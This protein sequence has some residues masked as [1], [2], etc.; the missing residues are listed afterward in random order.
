MPEKSD[1]RSTNSSMRVALLAVSLVSWFGA[2]T[3]LGVLMYRTEGVSA[4]LLVPVIL[5]S[6]V[7]SAIL[8][9]FKW[10]AFRGGQAIAEWFL[11]ILGIGSLAAAGWFAPKL[12][13]L[14]L[15]D[16]DSSRINEEW[17]AKVVAACRQRSGV[18]PSSQQD[19]LAVIYLSPGKEVASFIPDGFKPQV[20]VEFPD[21]TIWTN[22]DAVRTAYVFG[23]FQRT[24]GLKAVD[25][26]TLNVRV[27]SGVWSSSVDALDRFAPRMPPRL[28]LPN[29]IRNSNESNTAYRP[30]EEV[31]CSV[32]KDGKFEPLFILVSEG[33]T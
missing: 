19:R 30:N 12:W 4:T 33:R 32:A 2:L 22:A 18:Q 21:W 11:A 14:N 26:S 1:E 20:V 10:K 3:V 28:V 29:R 15:N 5:F 23:K 13:H 6:A 27:R 8:H 25:G 17:R 16:E 7:A 31:R 9:A 24:T